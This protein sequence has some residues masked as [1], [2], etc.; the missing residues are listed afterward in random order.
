MLGGPRALLVVA[1]SL[2]APVQAGP[3]AGAVPPTA[4]S[5]AEGG[6]ALSKLR[7][8]LLDRPAGAP[9]RAPSSP[10]YLALA[11][12]NRVGTWLLVGWV[13]PGVP[14]SGG[15][16]VRALTE[17]LASALRSRMTEPSVPF[18]ASVRLDT[19][20]EVPLVVVELSSRRPDVGRVVE[21]ELLAVTLRV[22]GAAQWLSP[23][24]RAVVEVHAPRA[25]SPVRSA[26]PA[27]HVI[28]RGETLSKIARSHGLDL[29]RLAKLNDLDVKRPIRAGEELRLSDKRPPLPKL[30]VVQKGDDLAKVARRFGIREKDLVEANRLQDRRLTSGQKLVLPR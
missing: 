29:E 5:G 7:A 20:G 21:E 13:L 23:L 26:K 9:L 16:D 11:D 30:Y 6:L 17:A 27:R 15:P 2:A 19:E 28:E 1:L 8:L 18:D 25:P 14:T 10:R 3:G 24:A 4:P 22:D 12:P